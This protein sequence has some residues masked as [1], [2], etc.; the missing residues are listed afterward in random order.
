MS[1]E[2][3]VLD[4]L[5]GALERSEKAALSEAVRLREELRRSIEVRDRL[6]QA[7]TDL[8]RKTDAADPRLS[9]LWNAA[10]EMIRVLPKPRL[11]GHAAV[12]QAIERMI[13]ALH[14]AEQHVD[15]IPF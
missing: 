1:M 13:A 3:L 2:E 6:D 15:L 11:T 4:R 9:E 10:S 14:A 12:T 7:L 5:I 8:R